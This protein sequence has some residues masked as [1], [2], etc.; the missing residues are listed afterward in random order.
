MNPGGIDSQSYK[1]TG[2][3]PELKKERR[4]RT[5]LSDEQKKAIDKTF[6]ETKLS[7][8]LLYYELKARGNYTPKNKLYEYLKTKGH[9]AANPK[10][11]KQRKRCRYERK[12]SGSLT[13][14]DWHRT[15]ENH[16]HCILWEDDASRRI[17]AGG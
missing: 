4:P 1:K 16:P 9:V 17:L 14:G 8:R 6:D 7:A 11:Q 12:H 13:H 3:M 5:C 2:K 15:T 10:K